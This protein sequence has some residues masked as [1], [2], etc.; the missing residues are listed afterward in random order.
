MARS[1]PFLIHFNTVSGLTEQSRAAFPVVSKVADKFT[2]SRSV[3][4]YY[5]QQ[6]DNLQYPIHGIFSIP[7]KVAG[8]SE[9]GPQYRAKCLVGADLRYTNTKIILLENAFPAL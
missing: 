2:T 3:C 7:Q 8:I 5:P 1:R 6:P 9:F 4:P